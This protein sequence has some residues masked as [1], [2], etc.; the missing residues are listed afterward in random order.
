MDT[1]AG[2]LL[3]TG[4]I[5]ILLAGV[6]VVRF[7]DIYARMHAAAKAPVLAIVLIALG[8]SLAVRTA[9]AI[10]TSILVIILQLLAGPVGAHILGRAVYIQDQPPL[11]GPDELADAPPAT[12]RE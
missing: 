9:A 8:V 2:L 1:V 6:G 3:V 5:L 11:D 4:S 10:I 7:T 12:S